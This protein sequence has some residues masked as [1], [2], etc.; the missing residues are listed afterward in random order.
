MIARENENMPQKNK[1]PHPKRTRRT[2]KTLFKHQ[3]NADEKKPA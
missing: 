1:S 2:K 3:K